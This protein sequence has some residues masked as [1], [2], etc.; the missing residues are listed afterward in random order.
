[1]FP[2]PQLKS[3]Y[4]RFVWVFQSNRFGKSPEDDAIGRMEMRFGVTSYPRTYIVDPRTL[5]VIGNFGRTEKQ[6]LAAAEQAN[7]RPGASTVLPDLAEIDA[8]AEE[9][10]LSDSAE[11]AKRHL[12]HTD[13]VVSTCAV[14][15]LARKD[16]A[17]LASKARELLLNESDIVRFAVLRVIPDHPDTGLRDTLAGFVANP[18]GSRNPN[19]LRCLSLEALGACGTDKDLALIQPYAEAANPYNMLTANAVKG[20]LRLGKRFPGIRNE[21][22]AVLKRSY[23]TQAAS[24]WGG[25]RLTKAI[26][27]ALTELVAAGE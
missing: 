6:I 10:Q 16:P 7:L 1:M 27:E 2:S 26:D 12:E 17:F 4:D 24:S 25:K 3:I 9:V 22:R 5:E 21:C 19:V 14:K 15:V 11:L 8:L 13:I 23:P 18:K 20:L